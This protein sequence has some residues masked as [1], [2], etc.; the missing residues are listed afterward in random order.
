VLKRTADRLVGS[1]HDMSNANIVF[2]SLNAAQSGIKLFFVTDEDVS[3]NDGIVASTHLQPVKGT[4]TI[5]Q[6]HSTS[7]GIM[8]HRMLSCYCGSD[9]YCMCN[10][11]KWTTIDFSYLQSQPRLTGKKN[12]ETS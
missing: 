7:Y 12:Y 8:K 3:R 6:L 10:C 11:F 5:R 9:S 4:M 2:N 1:G